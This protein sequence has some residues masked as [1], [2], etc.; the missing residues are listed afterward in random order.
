[1]ES[2]V[3]KRMDERKANIVKYACDKPDFE[4]DYH[5]I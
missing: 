4:T 3:G 1:M 2:L 5:K